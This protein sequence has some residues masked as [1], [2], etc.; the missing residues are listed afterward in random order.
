MQLRNYENPSAPPVYHINWFLNKLKF[1]LD[2]ATDHNIFTSLNIVGTK[3]NRFN[4]LS[5][6]IDYSFAN[7]NK[8][9]FFT[10]K[11]RS[12]T[13][14]ATF[15]LNTYRPYTTEIIFETNYYYSDVL[16]EHSRVFRT[17]VDLLSDWGGLQQII[18]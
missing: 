17:W 9:G 13:I 3:D 4:F 14:N 16:F 5:S 6:E 7:M 15:D 10:D 11:R 1:D 8:G 18:T 2:K 12:R